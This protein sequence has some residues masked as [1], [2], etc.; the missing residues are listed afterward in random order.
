MLAEKAHMNLSEFILSYLRKDF[1]IKQKKPN[2]KTLA[3]MKEAE[4]GGGIE[5][6]SIDDFWEKM[7][8]DRSA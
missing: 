4:E 6:D 5:C 3:A 8:I 1:P 2:K 7:G